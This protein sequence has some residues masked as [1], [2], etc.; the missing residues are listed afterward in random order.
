MEEKKIKIKTLENGNTRE[1]DEKGN[2]TIK[3]K[4]G[5]VVGF[6]IIVA[7]QW[8]SADIERKIFELQNSGKLEE[9]KLEQNKQETPKN[10]DNC[11]QKLPK[12]NINKK[13][14]KHKHTPKRFYD[15]KNENE[16]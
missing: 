10:L 12:L 14:K 13:H 3:D 15:N 1:T 4:D 7:G 2:F 8:K 16:R 9:I 6:G 5:K 11:I